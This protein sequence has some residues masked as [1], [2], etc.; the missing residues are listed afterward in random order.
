MHA[1]GNEVRSSLE[2]AIHSIT[3]GL[4]SCAGKPTIDSVVWL[5]DCDQEPCVYGLGLFGHW[6]SW[7]CVLIESLIEVRLSDPFHCM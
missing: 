3:C 7:S 1:G 4:S 2:P 6:H 5:R